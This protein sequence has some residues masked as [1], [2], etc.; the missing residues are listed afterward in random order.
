MAGWGWGVKV[1]EAERN[2]KVFVAEYLLGIE[3]IMPRNRSIDPFQRLTV[4]EPPHSLLKK[5]TK[6][7]S[8]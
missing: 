8:L 7:A 2:M 5:S 3:M 6:L 1:K 4:K